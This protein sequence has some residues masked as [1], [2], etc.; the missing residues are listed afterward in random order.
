VLAVKRL[1]I[2]ISLVGIGAA[3]P[4]VAAPDRAASLRF[5][6]FPHKAVQ[7]DVLNVAVSVHPG[8]VCTLVVRY[9]DGN[10]DHVGGALASA[11]GRAAWKWHVPADA[12]VGRARVTAS[13]GGVGRISRSVIVTGTIIPAHVVVEK[14]GFSIRNNAFA[15]ASVSF[16]VVLRNESPDEDALQIYALVNMV[17]PD[18]KLIGTSSQN[19]AGLP[20][21]SEYAL[22]GEIYFP[23][24]APVQRLEVVVT[25]GKHGPKSLR[26]PLFSNV[27]PAANPYEPA[28]LGSVEGEVLNNFAGMT[29]Q[30]AQISAVVFDAAGNVI[31][32]G[33]GFSVASLPPL[34]R[35]V[36]VLQSGF[37]SIPTA[38]AASAMVSAVGS[39]Q[40]AP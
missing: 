32:G 18:N 31:G 33:T 4:A 2:L 1:L 17:G 36:F 16:G 7:R 26:A 30:N 6:S 23:G 20:A 34:A 35:E 24:A 14:S 37:R 40:P 19:L 10:V 11:S 22:G 5:T 27:H 28:W 21:G 8:T 25:V 39:Y 15:G 29:M 12:K 38:N 3:A 9:A 13:C